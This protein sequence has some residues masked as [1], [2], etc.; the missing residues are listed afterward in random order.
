MPDPPYGVIWQLMK[1]G[2]VVPFLGAGASLTGRS[3]DIR[4]DPRRPA[5]LPNGLELAHVLATESS[6]P[7]ARDD[8]LAKVSSYYAEMAGRPRLRKRLRELIGPK[9][10]A[11]SLHALLASVPAPQLIVVTNYDTLLEAA[12]EAACKP[13]DL[14]VYPTDR[15]DLKNGLLWWE[16]GAR[17]PKEVAPNELAID[18]GAKTVIF[19]M[20]GT[21][22]PAEQWD[23]FV[24][25]EEDYVEF[26]S[27]MTEQ[28]AI[29]PL[30]YEH[31]R[32]R[33][34]LFLG[35]GL[36]DWNLRVVW[37]N[38]SKYFKTQAGSGDDELPSWAIQRDPS[39]LEQK[40][41]SRRNVEIFNVELDEFA[42]KLG[43]WK[44]HY[45]GS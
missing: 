28:G 31:F 3:P 4:Y 35:Y 43:G 2:K 39:V 37:R 36:R 13:F 10:A 12:F 5:F 8:D 17:A 21:L 27:R 26:L 33:S 6:F 25:T 16:H 19:K 18:L 30:F 24:I 40:L 42:T 14:V 15:K 20:H 1:D 11:G 7:E 41:W 29:P 23:S 22:G 9:P 34:F 44:T 45:D 32:S 38:L